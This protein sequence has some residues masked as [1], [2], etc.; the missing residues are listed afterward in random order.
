M[1]PRVLKGLGLT[2]AMPVRMPR[3]KRADVHSRDAHQ[4]LQRVRNAEP[5]WVHGHHQRH[6]DLVRPH[7]HCD[8]WTR[9]YWE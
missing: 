3:E 7:A 5:V 6:V 2:Q 8:V 1:E 9:Q 4:E